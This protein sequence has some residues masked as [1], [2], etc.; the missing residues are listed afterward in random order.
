MMNSLRSSPVL[1]ALAISLLIACRQETP[2]ALVQVEPVKLSLAYPQTSALDLTWLPRSSLQV[3]ADRLIVFVHLLDQQGKLVRTFD[4]PFPGSWTVG[5]E[6]TYP[7]ELYQSAIDPPV[8]A[9]TY[10]LTIGLYEASG[11]RWPLQTDGPEVDDNEYALAQV[12]VPDAS[13]STPKFSFSGSWTQPEETGN[14]QT[15][16]NQWL[17][18]PEGHLMIWGIDQ[19]GEAVL[20][21]KIPEPPVQSS[22]SV[23]AVR[24]SSRCAEVRGQV[25]G[26]GAHEVRVAVNPA[27]VGDSCRVSFAPNFFRV[28]E[29]PEKGSALLERASWTPRK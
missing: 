17:G 27:A 9:A 14:R 4:H 23:P 11:S 16:A 12:E 19:P 6:V 13:R 2:V 25:S 3:S 20:S 7:L 21:F 18:H 15:L 5:Q 1:P 8:P 10:A 26:H 29:E 22:E 28:S 24:I